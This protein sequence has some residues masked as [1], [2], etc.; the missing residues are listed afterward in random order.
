MHKE[1]VQYYRR[2]G[3]SSVLIFD[4]KSSSWE[5]T[6]ETSKLVLSLSHFG[7]TDQNIITYLLHFLQKS[8]GYK[9][10][11]KHLCH[12]IS[13]LEDKVLSQ[14]TLIAAT[15][16]LSALQ[17]LK[18]FQIYIFLILPFYYYFF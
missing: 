2:S 16:R 14:W 1:Q 17:A 15:G 12:D 3:Y 7:F 9:H 11:H 13:L 6:S 10:K 4:F 8:S 5:S 18:H